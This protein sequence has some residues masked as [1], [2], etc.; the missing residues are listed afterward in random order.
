MKNL[1]L[2]N[3]VMIM[4][5]TVPLW[6]S[7]LHDK[8]NAT[9]KLIYNVMPCFGGN[10]N[11]HHSVNG[12][13]SI[14]QSLVGELFILYWLRVCY[15]AWIPLKLHSSKVTYITCL[16]TKLHCCYKFVHD[17]HFDESQSAK[18]LSVN[19]CYVLLSAVH[20]Y[21]IYFIMAITNYSHKCF[22]YI[23]HALHMCTASSFHL[24]Q[25]DVVQQN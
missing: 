2:R 21:L 23:W 9:F 16:S 12:V 15:C 3:E 22:S 19:C 8:H 20:N 5:W 1:R 24:M 25:C 14:C 7:S 17:I 6:E 4:L 18:I 11:Y 13:N 10:E